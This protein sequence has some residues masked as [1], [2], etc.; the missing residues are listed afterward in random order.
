MAGYGH[1]P[2]EIQRRTLREADF[3]S[4]DTLEAATPVTLS[5][6]AARRVAKILAGETPGSM[7][8]VSVEGGGCSGLQYK[9]DVVTAREEDDLVIERDG[10]TVLVDSVS[11]QYMEG[12]E[13]DFIDDLMGQSFQIR[14]PNAVAGCGCGTSFTI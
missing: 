3:M 6:R 8:R 11:L 9:Y 10:A 12:S 13:I 1:F 14:N 2:A 5:A 4:T 7:L